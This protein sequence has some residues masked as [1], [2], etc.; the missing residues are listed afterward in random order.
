M[1]RRNAVLLLL[2]VAAVGVGIFLLSSTFVDRPLKKTESH[3]G[4]KAQASTYLVSMG[5]SVAAGDGLPVTSS[6]NLA[7][8]CGQSNDAY[9]FL[10]AQAKGLALKQFACS[11]ATVSSGILKSQQVE[12][13]SLQ[14]Q[15]TAASPYLK[16]SDIV[17]TIG[18][19]DVDWEQELYACATS[20][21]GTTSNMTLFQQNLSQLSANLATMLQTIHSLH[22]RRVLLNTY[23]PLLNN[24][25]TCLA[26]Q[27]IT[28]GKIQ[29]VNDREAELNAAINSAAKE[30]NY[31]TVLITFAGHLLCDTDPWIQGLS[32][33]APLHPTTAGQ[34]DIAGLDE[35]A[36]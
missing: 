22:P 30:F 26:S 31:Q 11:G 33:A 13:Q 28:A 10:V 3:Q 6:D 27:G 20:D 32:S 18:A 24:T 1:R 25:D 36:L 14:P 17:I 15:L 8:E 16:N 4:D 2:S 35:N 21:C 29:W 7:I 34:A 12:G 9:P 5:D 23:Y 19:N